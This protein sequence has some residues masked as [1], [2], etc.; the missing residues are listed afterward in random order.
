MKIKTEAIEFLGTLA[1]SGEVFEDIKSA[2]KNIDGADK[3]NTEK[4][5]TVFAYIKA[6]GYPI[7]KAALNF[8]IWLAVKWL[9]QRTK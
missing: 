8:S 3:S 1:A 7:G 4:H 5:N 2:V 9:R 6:I